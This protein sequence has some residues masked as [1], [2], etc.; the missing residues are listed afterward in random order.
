MRVASFKFIILIYSIFFSRGGFESGDESCFGGIEGA[1]TG[2]ICQM[3]KPGYFKNVITFECD[4]CEN[5]DLSKLI[6]S[7]IFLGFFF[8]IA[9]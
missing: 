3:C 1:Y 5:L 2:I 9:F 7:L 8:S 4:K 6:L